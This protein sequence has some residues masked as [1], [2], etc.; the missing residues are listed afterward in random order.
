M[1]GK[2]P[3]PTALRSPLSPMERAKIIVGRASVRAKMHSPSPRGRGGTARRWVRGLL[4]K[5]SAALQ[6]DIYSQKCN[7]PLRGSTVM[8]HTH[9]HSE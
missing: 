8:R 4:G 5:A 1:L 2:D 9:T 7:R 6:G 3:S